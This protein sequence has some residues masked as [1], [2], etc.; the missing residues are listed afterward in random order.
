MMRE[1]RFFAPE[2]DPDREIALSAEDAHHLLRVLRLGAG[3]EI[4]LFDG[5]GH[6]YRAVVTRCGRR[7][8][9]AR[10]LELLPSRESPL[11]LWIAVAA[12]KGEALSWMIQKLTEL[13]ANRVTPL[14]AERT[15]SRGTSVK[16]IERCRRVAAEACKQS[17]RSHLPAIDPP[18]SLSAL[19]E[20]A[21]P[22]TRVLASPRGDS[23]LPAIRPAS[24]V[25]LVGPEGGWTPE[26]EA[27]ALKAGFQ[28][29]RMGPRT[30]RVETAAI[31]VATLLQW[32]WGD[33]H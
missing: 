29:L 10:C 13:G 33:L 22:A 20:T 4:V 15:V 16:R 3:D 24:C 1:R 7:S 32:Q 8:A 31:A 12:P 18:I 26:E 25:A 6:A 9:F 17:G 21:L 30:L 5:R 2:A 11:D 23:T 28:P 27:N 19:L 14:L